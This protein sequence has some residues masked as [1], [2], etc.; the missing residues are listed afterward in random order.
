MNF[1]S[2]TPVLNMNF[3]I[4]A[5]LPDPLRNPHQVEDTQPSLIIRKSVFES[6]NTAIYNKPDGRANE[7]SA[8]NI[9]NV[10]PKHEHFISS[11]QILAQNRIF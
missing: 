7:S 3:S 11:F 10:G 4:M 6:F 2:E 5:V 9:H 1:V 8:K